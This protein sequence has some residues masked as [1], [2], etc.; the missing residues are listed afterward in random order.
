ME[1][2]ISWDSFTPESRKINLV[3][4]LTHLA[5]MIC[6][7]G[8][9]KSLKLFWKTGILRTLSR[10]ISDLRDLNL[11]PVKYLVLLN[12]QCMWNPREFDLLVRHSQTKFPRRFCVVFTLSG[13]EPSLPPELP[14]CL[15]KRMS[16]LYCNKI[17]WSLS[18][19][20]SVMLT[21]LVRLFKSWRCALNSPCY[22]E[23]VGVHSH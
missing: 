23:Y 17:W 18:F 1:S 15:P 19:N 16:Y 11:I 13:F 10:V 14:S 22:E 6:S 21:I 3:M 12:V 20:V 7:I 2:S 5:L 8:K 9:K 4:C